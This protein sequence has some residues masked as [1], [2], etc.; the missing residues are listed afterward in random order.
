MRVECNLS[1]TRYCSILCEFNFAIA[2]G[3]LISRGVY[4]RSSMEYGKCVI[5]P[6]NMDDA[7]E[8]V[9]LFC[10]D[11]LSARWV[12]KRGSI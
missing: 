12:L 9:L 2:D 5:S 10:K 7:R 1:G 11:I 6:I 8:G 4:I 3:G